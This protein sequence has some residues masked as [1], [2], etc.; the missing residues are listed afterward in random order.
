MRTLYKIAVTELKT[1]FYSPIAWLLLAIF[2]VQSGISFFQITESLRKNISLGSVQDFLTSQVFSQQFG[3]FPDVQSNLYLYLPLLTMGLMSRETSSGSIKLLLSSPIKI[4]DIILGKYLA[5]MVYGL[6]L[7]FILVLLVIAG[8]VAI[9]ALDWPLLISGLLGIYL[10]LCAYAAIGL[11]LSCLTRY[12]VVAAISTLMVFAI[13]RF[14]GSVGQDIDY[15]R[16][17]THSISLSGRSNNMITGMITSRDVLYFLIII[18]TFLTLSIVRLQSERE[19]RHWG[20]FAVRYILLLVL[21]LSL[22]YITSLPSLTL[23][24]D[25][26][27]T[28]VNTLTPASKKVADRIKGPLK[29]TTYV[30]LLDKSVFLGLPVSRNFDIASLSQYRRFI[31]GMQTEYVYYY[32]YTDGLKMDRENETPGL[33]SL[34]KQ[35]KKQA[36]LM[37]LNF[38]MFKSPEQIRQAIDLKPENNKLVRL[39]EY[40]G[41]RSFVRFYDDMTRVASEAE[42]TAA[43]ERLLQTPPKVG[44]ITG[45]D[46]RSIDK[47]GDRDYSGLTSRKDIRMSLVN[48]GFDVEEIDLASNTIA[49]DLSIVVLADPLRPLTDMEQ[50]KIS[51]YLTRGGNMIFCG[52]PGRQ[53]M[54]NPL[55][56]QLGIQLKEGMLV[57]G[58][59]DFSPDLLMSEFTPGSVK[60]DPMF[61]QLV[62]YKAPVVTENTTG[63]DMKDSG[64]FEIF[65]ILNSPEGS[66]NTLRPVNVSLSDFVFDADQG[67]QMGRFPVMVALTR[68]I[69]GKEQKII[70]SGDSDF[71]SNSAGR[72]PRIAN[73]PLVTGMFRWF[74]DGK[75]P[76]NVERPVGDDNQI[77]VSKAQ[78]YSYKIIL[79]WILP[80]LIFLSGAFL[81]L[82]RRR[83]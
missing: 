70:V 29:I 31:P 28:G 80:F 9:K 1:L 55:L 66:W 60:I 73:F 57:R 69:N 30:N 68:R 46:E 16:D 74:T 42:I 3:L 65:P 2:S 38:N 7:V 83:Q 39:L 62:Q 21:V 47:Q 23:Y 81:L 52:E 51:D 18:G 49:A 25:M 61:S 35:A 34:R 67:D 4:R 53:Q 64:A 44:F 43:L 14:I 10:L 36:E 12:Q 26:T 76:V 11:F 5:I 45:H 32:D 24:K 50:D 63:I 27:A 78:L 77:L 54:L 72:R 40:K 82:K 13:L 41:K 75:F 6:L 48:Q 22:G 37:D 19:A 20:V 59:K 15:I 71:M 8:G 17:L 79:V 33:T 56:K 58:T